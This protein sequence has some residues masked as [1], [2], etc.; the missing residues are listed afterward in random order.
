MTVTPVTQQRPATRTA[1]SSPP[2]TPA[3]A[4]VW[5]VRLLG[6][7]QIDDGTHRLSRL[8]SRAAMALLARV[9]MAPDRDH[10]REELA[11]M[12]WPEADAPTGRNRLRQTLSMLKAVL[13]PPGGPVV[14][15]ADR[16]VVRAVVGALWCDVVAFEQAARGRQ[17]DV[18]T[19][20][21]GGELLPGFYD[22]WVLDERNRLHALHERL[23]E[24]RDAEAATPTPVQTF[25]A[26]HTPPATPPPPAHP[27]S[28]LPQYLTRLIGADVQGARL[29]TLVAEH[30]LVSVLGAGG[31]GKTRLAIEVARV[32]CEAVPG[33]PRARFER[34]VFVSL[35]GVTTAT[36][37]L[38]RL[39]AALRVDT[40]ADPIAQVL[41]V[42]DRRALLVVLDNCEQLDDTAATTLA[43]L[44]EQLPDA[45]WLVTSRRPLCLDGEQQFVLDTLELPAP[46]APLPEVALNAA[47]L[48]F[49]DR[50]RAHRADF[51]VGAGNHQALVALVRW[52]DGL[53][54]AIELAASHTRTLGPAE[55]LA[56]LQA[57]RADPRAG[58]GSLAFLARRGTRGGSDLR[59]ASMLEVVAWTWRLL[60]PSHQQLLLALCLLP[61]GATLRC[62]AALGAHGNK[63]WSL[64][65]AQTV[66]DDLVAQ[67]VLRVS[68]G[69]DG[70]WRYAPLEPVRE[71]GLSMDDGQ[72]LR[73]HRQQLLNWL[74]DW[75][76]GM[77]PTPPLASVRDEL[78]NIA[79]ALARAPADGRADDAVLLVLMLQSSWG[80]IAVP[81]EV[82]DTLHLL[83]AA[84]GVDS[85]RR[86]CGHA[87]AA[88]FCHDAG[89]LDDV[90]R[91]LQQALTQP[92]PDPLLR[93][94]LLSRTARLVWR[95]DRDAPKARELIEQALPL[96][97]QV[98]RPNT[99]ASLL[100]L[101][102]HLITVVDG[103][104]ARGGE[105]TQQSLALWQRSGNRH[106]INAGRY[107]MA[108]TTLKAGRPADALVELSALA[109]EGRELQDWDLA[110]GALEAHGT[111][112]LAL[113]RW[114]EAWASLREALVV[115]WDGMQVQAAVYALWN[116]APVLARLREGELAAQTMAAAQTQW[117]QRFG[118]FDASD[119]RNL[120]RLRRFVHVLLGP[121]AAQTAWTTGAARPL[122]E[123]VQAVLQ[124]RL[125]P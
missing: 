63:A 11:T 24:A 94:S 27:A 34:P 107:N 75:T 53:P 16:R 91:H 44:A 47:V 60:E 70:Q 95:V 100:S 46:D 125:K 61:A 8:R 88:T 56:V 26:T 54:L 96:A 110:S 72:V 104:P 120:K 45:H 83:L 28:R 69:Q 67:S 37:L 65:Q 90:R 57:A 116:V 87:L 89:R 51:H 20:L 43:R 10:S 35:V 14:L 32:M 6:A 71:Y 74:L 5:H 31:G 33:R 115:A 93:V 2:A 123:A 29:Q 42:L 97:Q 77:P 117:R 92:C 114:P 112:L 85:S 119:R 99:E 105:F 82:L 66:L 36:G 22:E 1:T 30:R 121:Q 81:A 23:G 122:G 86:A 62:A 80:E 102:G 58:A 19:A 17:A 7:F 109:S 15:L 18:A 13:E 103:D 49:V 21:Y 76:R 113:R 39:C 41:G 55:L 48:L 9:A 50:A 98:Q 12:L 111:A 3:D 52:L 84:P 40:G 118:E 101:K 64:A 106:L 124:V 59:H 73:S 38:D 4:A 25:K 78:P 68:L 79:L 108:V